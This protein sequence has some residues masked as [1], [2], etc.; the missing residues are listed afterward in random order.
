MDPDNS[1]YVRCSA[2]EPYVRGE[3]SMGDNYGTSAEKRTTA[4]EELY[5]FV[6]LVTVIRVAPSDL[7]HS[8]RRMIDK[9][10]RD[11]D[12]R[13]ERGER[14]RERGRERDSASPLRGGDMRESRNFNNTNITRDTTRDN[15]RN[16]TE[17]IG[18]GTQKNPPSQK[19]VDV[20]KSG[21]FFSRFSRKN[22]ESVDVSKKDSM[23][24]GVDDGGNSPLP[25]RSNTRSRGGVG[26]IDGVRTSSN[27]RLD[28][29]DG[30]RDR[31]QNGAQDGG[32]SP[33]SPQRDQRGKSER[34]RNDRGGDDRGDRGDRDDS[35]DREFDDYVEEKPV[36][37]EMCS[38][39]VM[40]PIAGNGEETYISSC[41][42]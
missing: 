41:S 36:V 33:H 35:F 11:D 10:G 15:M 3:N 34:D 28:H 42:N 4:F 27:S 8:K 5:L 6:E 26:G 18:T 40:I 22:N 16:S 2:T 31:V 14:G 7:K 39:W 12:N 37:V 1:C 19:P 9:V 30:G 17:K 13:G 20:T 24:S 25:H 38:G 32:E 29:R 21:S 23:Q